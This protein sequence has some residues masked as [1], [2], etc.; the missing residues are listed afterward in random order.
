MLVF[1]LILM[2]KQLHGLKEVIAAVMCFSIPYEIPLT[3]TH[4]I[5]LIGCVHEYEVVYSPV[6]QDNT[7]V[8]FT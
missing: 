1:F 3:H 5:L 6:T 4:I 7:T 2:S 8:V